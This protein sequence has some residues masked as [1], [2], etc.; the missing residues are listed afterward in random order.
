MAQQELT[1]AMISCVRPACEE[2]LNIPLWEWGGAHVAPF[3]P[4]DLQLLTAGGRERGKDI[5]FSGAGTD[6]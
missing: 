3:T 1:V 5:F 6:K 2:S 4:N